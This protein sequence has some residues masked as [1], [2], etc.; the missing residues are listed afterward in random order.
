MSKSDGDAKDSALLVTVLA[1]LDMLRDRKFRFQET[2][3]QKLIATCLTAV[4][5]LITL[6][7]ASV[8]LL[9]DAPTCADHAEGPKAT[10]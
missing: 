2:F 5:S 3:L 8:G 10:S 1:P 7:L 9:G 6:P 4:A